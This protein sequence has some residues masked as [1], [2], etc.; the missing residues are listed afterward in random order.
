MERMPAVP[1]KCM[2]SRTRKRRTWPIRTLHVTRRL[3]WLSKNEYFCRRVPVANHDCFRTPITCR[4]NW[5]CC[6]DGSKITSTDVASRSNGSLH[7]AGDSFLRGEARAG[8]CYSLLPP[9]TLCYARPRFVG[10]GALP[11]L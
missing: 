2:I 9:L 4:G 10:R 11:V 6:S 7:R 8:S 1:E 3:R 5:I